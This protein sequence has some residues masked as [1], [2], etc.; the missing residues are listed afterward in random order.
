MDIFYP[1]QA[2][3]RFFAESN[4]SLFLPVITT[5]APAF[6]KAFAISKP[7]LDEAPVI[8]AV[9]LSSNLLIGNSTIFGLTI[10][11]G[12]PFIIYP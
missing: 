9:L 1:P 12:T 5:D 6:K 7:I 2:I 8:M 10:I 11:V 3:N 4:F